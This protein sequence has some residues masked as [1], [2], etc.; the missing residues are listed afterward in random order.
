[1]RL[2]TSCSALLAGLTAVAA[3]FSF[4]VASTA[5]KPGERCQIKWNTKGLRGPL[6]ITLV[7]TD[8]LGSS[9]A[10]QRIAVNVENT[11][12]LAWAP[13]LSIA[14][15]PSFSMI[16]IDSRSTT[17]VSES[18]LIGSLTQQPAMVTAQIPQLATLTAKNSRGQV[19]TRTV[20]ADMKSK[21]VPSPTG[22]VKL[23]Q[24]GTQ[25]LDS[26]LGAD[27]TDMAEND[28]GNNND[29]L[30]QLPAF[31]G[32]SVQDKGGALQPLPNVP[33]D[34]SQQNTTTT[35]EQKEK[36]TQ[37][38]TNRD[39]QPTEKSAA[40]AEKPA[41]NAG[42]AAKST[43]STSSSVAA[44]TPTPPPAKKAAVRAQV[45]SS[46]AA[47]PEQPPAK[48]AV[49]RVEKSNFDEAD[50]ADA[51]DASSPPGMRNP[52]REAQ[53][54]DSS[55]RPLPG[56][57]T[58][59]ASLTSLAPRPSFTTLSDLTLSPAPVKPGATSEPQK[60]GSGV[61]NSAASGVRVAPGV[62]TGVAG[63]AAL[64]AVAVVI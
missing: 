13:D 45:T 34:G 54:A 10:A 43:P 9:I 22:P 53:A 50:A 56:T 7:P 16:I 47:A 15:F 40:S 12:I 41:A 24:S 52:G 39:A 11:G 57:I 1:M 33:A 46:A 29:G 3:Q 27:A 20:T 30:K 55:L 42:E 5:L 21:V 44:P 49:P 48:E 17:I 4:P 8:A 37:T 64:A 18:F 25:V 59:T 31:A 26:T 62:L 35:K 28:D 36:A 58:E 51:A 63:L 14:A 6:S 23:H 32:G 60:S 19:V 61:L 38:Q 2:G